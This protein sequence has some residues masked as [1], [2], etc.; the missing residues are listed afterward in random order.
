MTLATPSSFEAP[1][2]EQEQPTVFAEGHMPAVEVEQLM[3]GKEEFEYELTDRLAQ[4]QADPTRTFSLVYI[5]LDNF[6]QINDQ[7]GHNEGDEAIDRTKQYLMQE[8]LLRGGDAVFNNGGDEFAL[9]LDTSQREPRDENEQEFE[10]FRERLVTGVEQAVSDMES[11]DHIGV[12]ASVGAEIGVR[13]DDTV[14]SLKQ[15]ADDEMYK[16]KALR[17]ALKERAA[18]YEDWRSSAETNPLSDRLAFNSDIIHLRSGDYEVPTIDV[19]HLP[20][21]FYDWARPQKRFSIFFNGEAGDT[22]DTDM[23][24]TERVSD[25][26]TQ[27]ASE[28]PHM[29]NALLSA[30]EGYHSGRQMGHEVQRVFAQALLDFGGQK[31]EPRLAKELMIELP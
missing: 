25:V 28:F 19:K 26:F 7:V 9:I 2:A 8:F 12:S 30:Y 14:E 22:P 6:K 23:T 3:G 20:K 16:E 21:K 1:P 18:V 5:D 31:L 24:G 27:F 15:R 4:F 10:N 17:K 29:T 13:P 11:I